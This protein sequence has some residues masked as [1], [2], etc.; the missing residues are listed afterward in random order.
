MKSV[1]PAAAVVIGMLLIGV[2]LVWSVLFPANQAW[3]TEKANRMTELGNQASTLKIQLNQA[4]TRPSMHAGQNPAELQEKYDQ[5]S[6]EYKALYEEFSSATQR[7]KSSSQA[8]RYSGFVC[9]VA[10]GIF[11]FATRER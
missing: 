10:G 5:I 9:I 11:L 8:L 6:R 2:S 4:Q 3:T 1:L 7:P